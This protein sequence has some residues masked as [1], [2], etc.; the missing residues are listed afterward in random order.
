M[1]IFA[2]MVGIADWYNDN[3]IKCK[4]EDGMDATI[5]FPTN[6]PNYAIVRIIEDG[7]ISRREEYKDGIKNGPSISWYSNGNKRW[8]VKH[9]S[10]KMNGKYIS[11]WENGN[12]CWEAE[13][14][15]GGR[16]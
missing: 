11:W 3:E 15:N 16:F 10:G 13:Y 1:L 2:K 8:E 12:I 4:Y 14:K 9:K 7:F 6:S 5:E